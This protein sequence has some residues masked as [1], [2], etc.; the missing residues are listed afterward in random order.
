MYVWA[1]N[2][3]NSQLVALQS[4][5]ARAVQKTGCVWASTPPLSTFGYWCRIEVYTCKCHQ[6]GPDSNPEPQRAS[7]RPDHATTKSFEWLFCCSHPAVR[8]FACVQVCCESIWNGCAGFF[9]LFLLGFHYWT[10]QLSSTTFQNN[11]NQIYFK[12][13]T[14][15]KKI[16][17]KNSEHNKTFSKNTV[18]TNSGSW[19]KIGSL[20]GILVPV[21]STRFWFPPRPLARKVI[22]TRSCRI[23]NFHYPCHAFGRYCWLF[24]VA[25]APL[26][27]AADW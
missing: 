19:Y 5:S 22:K 23:L 13:S 17:L 8:N 21:H 16:N 4:V 15:F 10:A 11:E 7:C 14:N 24:A 2:E 25:Q 27:V 12:L 6:H 1:L 9:C 3:A 26:R 20:G 18:Q